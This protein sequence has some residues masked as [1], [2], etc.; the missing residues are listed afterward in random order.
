MEVLRNEHFCTPQQADWNRAWTASAVC[1]NFISSTNFILRQSN[2]FSYDFNFHYFTEK[3]YYVQR[4]QNSIVTLKACVFNGSILLT[5]LQL[6]FRP[7]YLAFII[8]LLFQDCFLSMS[9]SWYQSLIKVL[10]NRFSQSCRHF[11]D[12]DRGI[13]YLVC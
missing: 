4:K 11:V 10:L 1:L 9:T 12:A 5:P 8:T 7:T 3:Q 2:L 6:F 13:Q